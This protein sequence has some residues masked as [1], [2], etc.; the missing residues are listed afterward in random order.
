MPQW[1]FLNIMWNLRKKEKKVLIC[2]MSKLRVTLLF[3]LLL[4]KWELQHAFPF[5]E[6]DLQKITKEKSEYLRK[7]SLV[8]VFLFS[9]LSPLTRM[10]FRRSL[11]RW[12]SIM[13]KVYWPLVFRHMKQEL[14]KACPLLYR[15][16]KTSVTTSCWFGQFLSFPNSFDSL[17]TT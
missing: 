9:P 8:C 12:I 15:G 7:T 11:S 5:L 1:Q 2:L 17:V 6:F 3:L 13:L 10:Y 16:P 4:E 14:W